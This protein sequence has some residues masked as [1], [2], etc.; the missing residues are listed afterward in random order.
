[1]K[2][3]YTKDDVEQVFSEFRDVL[4]ANQDSDP[5]DEDYTFRLDAMIRCWIYEMHE[6]GIEDQ[7]LFGALRDALAWA[8]WHA[9][10]E[11]HSGSVH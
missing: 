6:S 5:D 11:G 7:D 10:L 3:R 8:G 2:A 4:L 9:V 1:M